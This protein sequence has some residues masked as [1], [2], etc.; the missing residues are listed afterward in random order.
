MRGGEVI[1][2][3]AGLILANK[4]VCAAASLEVRLVPQQCCRTVHVATV[5]L[6]G[7]PGPR[8]WSAGPPY[9]M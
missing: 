2:R 9:L 1:Y 7:V 4:T 8:G 5:Q 3:D 6:Y